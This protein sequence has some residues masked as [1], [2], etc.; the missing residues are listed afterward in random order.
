V[1]VTDYSSIM[2]EYAA[3]GRPMVFYAF[4]LEE[5]VAARDF[6]VPFEH[7]VP[8]PIVRTFAD[9]LDAI[10]HAETPSPATTEFAKRH[11]A[12]LDDGSTDRVIDELVLAR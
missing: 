1:L 3:L 8:G 12:H 10:R 5:Y 6:Y 2:F 9:L 7:F 4:D 11:F